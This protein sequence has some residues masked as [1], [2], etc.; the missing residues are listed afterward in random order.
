MS[1]T[2]NFWFLNRAASKKQFPVSQPEWYYRLRN[3]CTLNI[4]RYA[5][6]AGRK[7]S[8]NIR[9]LIN[10]GFDRYLYQAGLVATSLPF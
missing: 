9:H 7:D 3:N 4:V 10:G 1:A 8:F 2:A 5:N 6:G